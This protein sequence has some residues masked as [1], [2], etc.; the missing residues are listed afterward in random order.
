L[1]RNCNII[2]LGGTGLLGT[3]LAQ[4]FTKNGA[5]VTLAGRTNSVTEFNFFEL[6]AMQ[7]TN[8]N[9]LHHYNVVIDCL[10]QVT[11]PIHACAYINT[12]ASMHIAKA[13]AAT[14]IYYVKISSLAVYGSS[15]TL[16]TEAS[17]CNPDSAYG[18][19]KLASENII[20]T[21]LQPANSLIIR[22]S[23]LYGDQAKKGVIAY[24]KREYLG[25]KK[26]H[27]DNDGTLLRFFIHLDDAVAIIDQ[28]IFGNK[29]KNS[30]IINLPGPDKMTVLDLI[31]T[32]ENELKI[33]YETILKKSDFVWGN[34]ANI[35]TEKLSAL[36]T[37]SYKNTISNYFNNLA[38]L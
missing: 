6:D 29:E 34:I 10:G 12:T 33:K 26:I 22:L 8:Y 13:L 31:A 17:H 36:S 3:A 24:L 21:V 25:S 18:A 32:A 19:L 11:N 30:G 7:C 1:N 28:L 20:T 5:N 15:N 2:I 14:T 23:N 9:F 37:V 35:S 27:F 4:H 16:I 38:Q